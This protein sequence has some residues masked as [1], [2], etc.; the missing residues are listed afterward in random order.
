MDSSK[1]YD[2][3]FYILGEYTTN[4]NEISVKMGSS[5]ANNS[6]TPNAY[7]AANMAGSNKESVSK[8]TDAEDAIKAAEGW[9]KVSFTLYNPADVF[10]II[11]QSACELY[12]DDVVVK[13]TGTTTNLLLNGGFEDGAEPEYVIL[14]DIADGWNKSFTGV[15]EDGINNMVKT[16]H[17]VSYSG[18]SSLYVKFTAEDRSNK[19]LILTNDAFATTAE[20]SKQYTITL[21]VRGTYGTDA[22]FRAGVGY[23]WG[24]SVIKIPTQTAQTPENAVKAAEGW[25]KFSFTVDT[26]EVESNRVTNFKITIEGGADMYIDDVTVTESGTSMIENSG[27]ESTVT[28]GYEIHGTKLFDENLNQVAEITAVQSGKTLTAVAYAKNHKSADTT[29]QIIVALY[30]ADGLKKVAL[31]ESKTLTAGGSEV[32]LKGEIALPDSMSDEYYIKVFI[33]DDL[34]GMVPLKADVDIF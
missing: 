3:S 29:A 25:K 23:D 5:F 22:D 4:S 32:K 27:F 12:I 10:Q 15:T 31:S 14:S 18:D 1:T 34:E 28:E 26:S 30:D 6:T 8:F 2:V 11:V 13:E 17:G 21:Y 7:T 16:A 19:Y 24:K 9:Q 20:M 33:W